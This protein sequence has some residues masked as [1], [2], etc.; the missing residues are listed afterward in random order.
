MLIL[1]WIYR[2]SSKSVY[3]FELL[4]GVLQ[5]AVYEPVISVALVVPEGLLLGTFQSPEYHQKDALLWTEN[6]A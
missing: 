6:E 5:M 2:V 1:S 4:P 3:L